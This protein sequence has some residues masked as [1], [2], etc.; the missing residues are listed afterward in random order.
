MINRTSILGG[1][2][3]TSFLFFVLDP[4]AGSADQAQVAAAKKLL[5]EYKNEAAAKILRKA[6]EDDP[7]NGPVWGLYGEALDSSNESKSAIEAY[8]KAIALGEKG[9]SVYHARGM[10]YSHLGNFE[11]AIADFTTALKIGTPNS[12]ARAFVHCDRADAELSSKRFCQAAED[13]TMYFKFTSSADWA[14]Y[15][16]RARAYA[17][18]GKIPEAIHDMSIF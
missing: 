6:L 12:D 17:G 5:H 10:A 3:A 9:A 8:T 2:L 16:H 18:C 13:Y 11:T 7:R 15:T 4:S 14:R 1:L